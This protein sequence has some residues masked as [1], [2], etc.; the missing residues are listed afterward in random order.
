MA[1]RDAIEIARHAE[2]VGAVP[3]A[4][5]V[6]HVVGRRERRAAARHRLVEEIAEDP[7]LGGFVRDPFALDPLGIG[8]RTE[9]RGDALVHAIRRPHAVQVDRLRIEPEAHV[10][11]AVDHTGDHGVTRRVDLDGAGGYVLARVPFFP[12]PR[13]RSIRDRECAGGRQRIVHRVH[14]SVT[15]EDVVPHQERSR[16]SLTRARS[17][18]SRFPFAS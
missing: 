5:R 10:V 1:E 4:D 12:D 7:A 2:P 6:M 13:D 18:C 14:P 17:A 8:M 11:V 9:P 16:S 3:V 15:D